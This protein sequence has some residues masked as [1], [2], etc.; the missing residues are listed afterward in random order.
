MEGFTRALI[1]GLKNTMKGTHPHLRVMRDAWVH[2][3]DRKLWEF[4]G[5]DG[6]YWWGRAADAYDARFKGW[7]AWL[8]KQGLDAL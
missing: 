1:W 6:F 5:P 4:H 3:S 7:S 2:T 8:E